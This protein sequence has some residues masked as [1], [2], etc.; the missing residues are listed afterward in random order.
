MEIKHFRLIKT[1]VEEGN[2]AKSSNKLF[3]TQS[4]ISHQLK[5][6]ET[7][8]GFPIFYRSRQKWKLTEEGQE[9][10][11]LGAK[12]LKDLEQG[13]NKID[14]LRLG[15][16]GNI[17]VSTECY[18]FYQDMPVFI[19][20]MGLL[21]ADVQVDLVLEATHQ[22]I[23]K[24][25]SNE[26]DIAIVTD[27]LD[28]PEL[29]YKEVRKDEIFAI[30]HQEHPF[31]ALDFLDA[32]HFAQIHLIIHSFPLESVSIHQHVLKPNKISPQKITAIPLTEVALEM[33]NAN[34]GVIC[35]P[36]WALN[37]FHLSEQLIFKQIGLNGLKR[38]HYLVSRKSDGGKKY[39]QEFMTNF[40]CQF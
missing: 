33:V 37:P 22:P 19:Q 2:I 3:L 12:I 9:L 4:A 39:I 13:F 16:S 29:E 8:L 36:K 27:K 31:S 34:M 11:H 20:K 21:Y 26:I 10:Y 18:S 24:L 38:T 40:M 5:E 32:S 1:I 30:M 14:L 6:L 15:V 35:L 25:L 17:R 23:A 28:Q 7:Q